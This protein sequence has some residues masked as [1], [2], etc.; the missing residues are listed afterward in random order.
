MSKLVWKHS[1]PET[2]CSTVDESANR[3]VPTPRD[4]KRIHVMLEKIR[5]IWEANPDQRLAQLIINAAGASQS[6]QDL[7]YLEDDV[8]LHGL[9]SF[10]S[11]SN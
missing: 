6:G 10:D 5:E 11:L 2:D 7:Y 4:P 9:T 1:R 8:L 3:F